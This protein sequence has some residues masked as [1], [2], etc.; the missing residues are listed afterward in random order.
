ME[1]RWNIGIA[2]PKHRAGTA[3][4]AVRGQFGTGRGPKPQLRRVLQSADGRCT[5]IGFSGL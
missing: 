5:W 3:S 2:Q 1:G 4:G